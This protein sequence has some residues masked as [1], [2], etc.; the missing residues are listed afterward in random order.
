MRAASII[1]L[2]LTVLLAAACQMAPVAPWPETIAPMPASPT[3][4]PTPAL[5]PRPSV[6]PMATLPAGEPP[7][8]A[9]IPLRA[10]ATWVYSVTLDTQE[11][12]RPVHW[13]GVITET[14]TEAR[15]T[16]ETVGNGWV[17]RVSRTGALP[18]DAP[19]HEPT[20]FYVALGGWLYQL[21]DAED[22]PDQIRELIAT[23]GQG[24]EAER[25]AA[26]PMTVG[27]TWGD[28]ELISIE[29]SAYRWLVEAQED[30]QTP[31]NGGRVW[32]GCLRLIFRTNPDVTTHWVCPG[33]GLVRY[34]YHHNGS[35]HDEVW[36]L[37]RYE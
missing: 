32:L 6:T 13:T 23:Q 8:L 2:T 14:V 24:F 15:R 35:R 9:L 4:T 36:E 18:L 27:Q 30:V 1:A 37:V 10:G 17:F 3:E 20:F 11:G 12:Y 5:P 22:A 28:P 19:P 25:I 29:G 21:F 26:W 33:I 34:Q 16:A 31:A 7:V